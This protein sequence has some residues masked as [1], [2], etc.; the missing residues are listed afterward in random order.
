MALKSCKKI[1]SRYK[2]KI[3]IELSENSKDI[4]NIDYL[5]VIK[6]LKKYNYSFYDVNEYPVKFNRKLFKNEVVNIFC[7]T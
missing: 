6:F 1:I 2:P 3:L 5:S 7:K 4:Y